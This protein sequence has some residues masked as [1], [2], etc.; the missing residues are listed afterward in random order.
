MPSIF[1]GVEDGPASVFTD[2]KL[3]EKVSFKVGEVVVFEVGM[4]AKKPGLH[5]RRVMSWH[6]RCWLCGVLE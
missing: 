2:P 1:A 4:R 3:G 6:L 5:W